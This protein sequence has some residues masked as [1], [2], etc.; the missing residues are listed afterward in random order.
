MDTAGDGETALRKTS[1]A[2]YDLIVSDWKMP[3]LNGYEFYEKLRVADP[4]VASRFVFLTGDVIGA[5]KL[6]NNCRQYQHVRAIPSGR[7][8][9]HRQKSLRDCLIQACSL[10]PLFQA[11]TRVCYSPLNK[12]LVCASV[13]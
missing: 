11:L 2:R 13:W 5:Q 4:D 9:G 1:S 10:F 6:L 8:S 3:G 7:T 12:R